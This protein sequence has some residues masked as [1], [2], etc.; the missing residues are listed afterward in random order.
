MT[1]IWIIAVCAAIW[2]LVQGVCIAR[3]LRSV[4]PLPEGQFTPEISDAPFVSIICPARDEA[5][6]IEAAARG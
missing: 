5:D 1:A 4:C 2:W 3:T 6:A